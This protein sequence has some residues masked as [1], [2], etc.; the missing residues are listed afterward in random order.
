MLHCVKHAELYSCNSRLYSRKRIFDF[1][2]KNM[3]EKIKILLSKSSQKIEETMP[4]KSLFVL[5][6]YLNPFPRYND[7]K[8]LR[9]GYR[10]YEWVHDLPFFPRN[11][12]YVFPGIAS[13]ACLQ[14]GIG[15]WSEVR[16]RGPS[17]RQ[18]RRQ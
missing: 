4:L 8:F 5:S 2:V 12:Y 17:K 11:V 10:Y 7:S 13:A 16:A 18:R 1:L 3:Q 15:Q 9:S 14:F 6:R